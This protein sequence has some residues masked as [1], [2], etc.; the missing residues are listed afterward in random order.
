MANKTKWRKFYRG[1]RCFTI[2]KHFRMLP[3]IVL[4]NKFSFGSISHKVLQSAR[5]L[6]LQRGHFSLSRFLVMTGQVFT[7]TEFYFAL[8]V[9]NN[10]ALKGRFGAQ[11]IGAYF[12]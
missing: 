4:A 7:F 11:Y 3:K 8:L 12:H 1:K 10:K 9:L 6:D 2:S 5:K